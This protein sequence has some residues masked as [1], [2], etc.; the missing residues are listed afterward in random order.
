MKKS[1]TD[2]QFKKQGK[3]KARYNLKQRKEQLKYKEA[4]SQMRNY[5]RQQR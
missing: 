5:G 3:R 2:N 1:S 4:F